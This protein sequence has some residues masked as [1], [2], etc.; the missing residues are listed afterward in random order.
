MQKDPDDLT[1]FLR[2]WN[3]LAQKLRVKMFHV[4]KIDLR[5]PGFVPG[6]SDRLGYGGIKDGTPAII[7]GIILF[8][9]PSKPNFLNVKSAP[10][11]GL[12]T[13]KYVESKIPWGVII[14]FGGGFAL[15]EGVNFTNI[16]RALF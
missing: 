6:W 12:V 1:V 11:R 13:W 2:F 3:L 10:S 9:L 5:S 7:V 14:L 15:A 16:L 4:G 8:I